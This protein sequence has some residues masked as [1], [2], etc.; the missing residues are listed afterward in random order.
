MDEAAERRVHRRRVA[1]IEQS[2]GVRPFG[3]LSRYFHTDNTAGC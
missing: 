1:S 2:V 3:W